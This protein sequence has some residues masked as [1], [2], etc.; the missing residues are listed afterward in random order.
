MDGQRLDD[1]VEGVWKN[2]L[3]SILA[4]AFFR[5]SPAYNIAQVVDFI[6]H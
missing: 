2:A 6:W 5:R 3:L 4:A 1:V